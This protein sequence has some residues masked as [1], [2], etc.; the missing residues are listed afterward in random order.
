MLP[1][2]LCLYRIW[3]NGSLFVTAGLKQGLDCKIVYV[4][5]CV[6]VGVCVWR[7]V[8]VVLALG[9]SVPELSKC[10]NIVLGWRESKNSSGSAS[11][12]AAS[13]LQIHCISVDTKLL[14][15]GQ[16]YT[17]GR[18]CYWR[19]PS[20]SWR[21]RFLTGIPLGWGKWVSHL[22][23]VVSTWPAT[24]LQTCLVPEGNWVYNHG[25]E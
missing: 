23:T 20:Q 7:L 5:V 1:C 21:Q 6:C 18:S 14:H 11:H 10:R 19:S 2:F 8:S 13:G 17:D 9:D 4:F 3:T 24:H 15:T 25:S 12:K 22:F 16:N